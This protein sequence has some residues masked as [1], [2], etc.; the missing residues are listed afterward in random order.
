MLLLLKA[1]DTNAKMILAWRLKFNWTHH[2]DRLASS[3]ARACSH[4]IGYFDYLAL[5]KKA[6]RE[7]F[8]PADLQFFFQNIL[9]SDSNSTKLDS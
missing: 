7:Q 5:S 6:M 3:S 8:E 2:L 1:T 4:L 9:A